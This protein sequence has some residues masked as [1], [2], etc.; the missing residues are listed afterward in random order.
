[1]LFGFKLR[2]TAQATHGGNNAWQ[3]LAICGGRKN[4]RLSHG[5]GKIRK[6]FNLWQ[7]QTTSPWLLRRHRGI[8]MPEQ[9]CARLIRVASLKIPMIRNRVDLL[10]QAA[11]IMVYNLAAGI[12]FCKAD[13]CIA[14]F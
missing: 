12:P 9:S 2:R 13:S 11:T 14:H 5:A 4:P 3:C 10:A 7:F 1:M 8:E 6:K